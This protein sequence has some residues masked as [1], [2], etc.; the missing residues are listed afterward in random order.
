M[1]PEL[2]LTKTKPATRRTLKSKNENLS[3]ISETHPRKKSPFKKWTQLNND[4]QAQEARF[5]LMKQSPIAYCVM[6]FLASNMDHYNAVICSYKVMQE[7]FGYSRAA[8]SDAIQL[9][10]KHR[11]ID[12]KKSGTSNVY[13]LNKQLYWN[14]W[15]SNYAYAEFGAK[16]IVSASEQDED[17]QH[18]ILLQLKRRQEVTL[19]RKPAKKSPVA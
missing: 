10:K 13:L 9:L 18:E 1:M 4:E 11:Y 16:I 15:G 5:W 19:A 6:D 2:L 17:T 14:S 8:L 12:V 3:E 7:R